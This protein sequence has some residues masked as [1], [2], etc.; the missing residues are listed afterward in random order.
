[1]PDEPQACP[2]ATSLREEGAILLLSCYELGHQPLSLASP[3][4][5][6]REAGYSPATLDLA[7][8][9]LDPERVA[10][11]RLVAISVPM[12]TAL[13]LGAKAA[14]RIRSLNPG[15]HLC[16]YG[17]YATLNA[18]NL[19]A[20]GACSTVGG[21]YEEPLLDFVQTLE[22]G[23]GTAPPHGGCAGA[24]P[25]RAGSGGAETRSAPRIGKIRFAVPRRDTLPPLDQYARLEHAGV[26]R[27]AGAT[28]ASRGCLHL[29]RHCPIPPVYGGRFFIVPRDIVLA[30]IR[31]QV[32][33]GATH[34]TFGDPDFLN[35]PGHSMAIVKAMRAEF[36]A[37][38]FDITAKIEHLLKHRNLLPGLAR[39]GCL[40]VVSAV[41]SLSDR[42]LSI[43]DKG[44]TRADVFEAL[45]LT[46][47][48]GVALRPSFVPFTPWATREDYHSLLEF[49][50]QEDLVDDLDPIQLAIRLLVPPGSLLAGHHEMLPLLGPLDPA[51]FTNLW[52]H[53]DPLM[54]RLQLDVNALVEEA[55]HRQEDPHE[56]FG[57]IM[58]RAGRPGFPPARRDKG[59]PPRLTE[60][61]FC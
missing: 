38:T 44:H 45:R 21:E 24:G 50:E 56:T 32:A 40:F 6:L 49:V 3:M 41:E 11:A 59:R 4:G 20:R 33:T 1:M 15:C 19:I 57:R 25:G 58:A 36:P 47:G 28:E 16:F 43:L 54:D 22:R 61:W 27:L 55:A 12:H 5:L 23:G 7:V 29:C 35:G 9:R 18:E 8:E 46:R 60:P 14:S 53:P 51:R 2:G 30:D 31:N 52:S 34:I 37:L 13:R 48:A 17:T 26:T 39:L 42:V 10:R